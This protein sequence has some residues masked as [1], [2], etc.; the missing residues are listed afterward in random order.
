MT[1]SFRWAGLG[2]TLILAA[3]ASGPGPG[4]GKVDA[5][6]EATIER[7]A[8]ERW[9][10]LIEDDLHAAYDYLTPGYRATRTADAYAAGAKPAIMTWTGIEWR[11]VECETGDSCLASLLL[12]YTVQMQGAGTVPGMTE[13]KERWVRLDGIWYHLPER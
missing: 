6:P 3:C 1:A 10:L 12:Q 4:A 13:V 8:V 11:D 5:S 9:N 7:R 2:L